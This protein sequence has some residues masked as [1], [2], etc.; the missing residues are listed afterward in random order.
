MRLR[1]FISGTPILL[2]ALLALG[3]CVVTVGSAE[4]IAARAERQLEG[5]I[6]VEPGRQLRIHNL[7][8]VARLTAIEGTEVT[9][10]ARVVAGGDDQSEADELLER[11]EIET[12]RED[13]D[14]LLRIV[15]PV[16]EF[17]RF[18]YERGDGSGIA[19]WFGGSN[20]RLEYQGERIEVSTSRRSGSASVHADLEIG[21]PRGASVRLLNAVGEAN[22][23]AIDGDLTL[24]V[25]A[26]SILSDGG[27]GALTA[28][29][30]SGSVEIRRR[31]GN[32]LADTGSGSV[33][34][35]SVVG[36]VR[37]D[38]GSGGVTVREVR[39]PFVGVDT[40]S[41]SVR[42]DAVE[43][44]ID[45][46]TGSG[47][48][49]G[50][51]LVVGERLRVDTGSGGIRLQ[52]DFSGMRTGDLDTGSGAITLQMSAWPSMRLD[53]RTSSGGI[54]VDLPDARARRSERDT[55]QGEVGDD[56]SAE[57]KVST[58]SGGIRVGSS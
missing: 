58:S 31:T 23:D 41:G 19:S 28:D 51:G 11:I 32:V 18:H 54:D 53:L 29:T 33:T 45:V 42:L 30:G 48:V 26:G 13:G 49:R 37:V 46:D 39:A 14:P 3:G 17:D 25:H 15:Y 16:D 56:P 24:V 50:E 4:P 52:G 22:A 35:E 1:R 47:A 10:L 27:V 6:A 44:P 20:T 40:G 12:G 57:L 7:A 55:W 21:V 38:T 8:G 5:S 9:V 34:V 2:S 36:E 43:G